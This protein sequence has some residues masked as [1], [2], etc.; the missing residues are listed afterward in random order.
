MRLQ[1]RFLP[2]D[3]ERARAAS[4]YFV[5]DR[6][7]FSSRGTSAGNVL[8]RYVGKAPAA[9]HIWTSTP[10]PGR[11]RRRRGPEADSVYELVSVESLNGSIAA[12]AVAG[13]S[14]VV[15]GPLSAASP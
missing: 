13:A 1:E 8:A 9:S 15:H 10:E 6:I 14:G 7:R 2:S 3:D 11:G 12:L 4:G 5:R